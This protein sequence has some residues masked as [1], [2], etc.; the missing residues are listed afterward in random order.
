[1]SFRANLLTI[2]VLS[3]L[4]LAGCATQQAAQT[5]AVSA[6]VVAKPAPT[7]KQTAYITPATAAWQVLPLLTVGD[8][9]NAKADGKPY[10]MVGV[11]DGLGAYL[12]K[13][14]NLVVLM[15]HELKAAEGIAR[16]HGGQGAFVSQ[17]TFDLNTLKA[18][19][20][21]DLAK[22]VFTWDAAA[23]SYVYNRAVTFDRLC[24]A[25][26]PSDSG[27]YNAASKLGYHGKIFLNGE[28]TTPE[29][30]VFAHI[31]TGDNAG[32]SFELPDLGKFAIENVLVHPNTG[33]M[34]LV[35]M[36]NDVM[37]GNVYFYVGQKQ[38]NG[39]EIDQ[40]GLTGG[41]LYGVRTA[42][43]VEDAK[44]GVIGAFVLAPMFGDGKAANKSGMDL[45]ADARERGVT[46]FSRPEDGVWDVK[47]A[48]VYY[49]VT[50]DRFDGNSRLYKM[51]FNQINNPTAGGFIESVL[52]AKDI[53]AQMF[54]NL[55]MTADG[56]I[57]LQEDPGK[58]DHLAAIWEFDPS[59]KKASKI[60][61][62]D[63]ARF[64]AGQAGFLTTDEENSGI[65]DVT[66]LVKNASWFDAGKKYLLGTTQAHYK[67]DGEL[68]Q[69]GQLYMISGPAK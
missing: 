8:S 67:M 62:S 45:M 57:Y 16:A 31:A 14:N 4:T 36:N 26:L 27:L 12:D 15:N 5:A 47:N 61:V 49:F 33:D 18:T 11:P 23:N 46:A 17:W 69:G 41:K 65:V 34:T 60:F 6:P 7:T 25:D 59:T 37:P 52:N 39:S 42:D 54:D 48:N 58:Q 21:Q 68:V 19:N 44:V 56:K 66:N 2:A 35:A 22:Q 10:Q 9:V 40:A 32:T 13:K 50:T 38:K 51:T 3:T 24:S 29:G 53:G 43:A 55:T 63:V 64:V 1:M 30:R 20:G 28:E